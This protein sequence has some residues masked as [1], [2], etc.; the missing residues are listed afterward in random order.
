MELKKTKRLILLSFTILLFFS[1]CKLETIE[2]QKITQ[3]KVE[4]EG[5]EIIINANAL[6]YNPNKI[7]GRVKE[8]EILASYNG[9]KIAEIRQETNNS[10]IPKHKEF[11]VPFRVTLPFDK[12]KSE[13]MGSILTLVGGEQLT[14]E[15]TGYIKIGVLGV[16][17]NIPINYT[18]SIKLF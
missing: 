11:R 15:Y 10:K 9:N 17:K 12:I 8:I 2:F 16:S 18:G 6:F 14:L 7:G 13:L 4:V 5:D 3:A 1:S